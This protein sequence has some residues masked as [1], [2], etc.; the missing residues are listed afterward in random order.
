MSISSREAAEIAAAN[1]SDRRPVVFVHGLWLLPTSWDP[2]RELFEQRGYATLAV[3]WP[4]D[5]ASVA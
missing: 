1:Q 4:R 3:D 2:W 5:P